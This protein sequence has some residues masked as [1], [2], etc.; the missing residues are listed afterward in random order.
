MGL[1]SNVEQALKDAIRAKDENKRNA[2]RL[3]LTA[4]KVKEKELKRPLDET[5]IQQAISSQIKQR[6]DSS[7]QFRAG[8]RNDL[9]EKEEEEIHILQAFLPEALGAE[10]LEQIIQEVIAEVGAQ[11]A[12][13]MGK[14]MKALMPRVTGRAEGK[15]VNDLVR[16]RLQG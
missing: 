3:L 4:L 8:G 10:V 2:I 14:V 6:R 9:S 5:E 12:K 11:S 15:Q 16:K 7:D 13:D 1:F